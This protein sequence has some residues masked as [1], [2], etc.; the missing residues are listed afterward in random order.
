MK[1]E[2]PVWSN[3]VQKQEIPHLVPFSTPFNARSIQKIT[4]DLPAFS[5]EITMKSTCT[6]LTVIIRNSVNYGVQLYQ[7]NPFSNSVF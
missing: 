5:S 2:H 1:Y 4:Y 6:K 3:F 7:P